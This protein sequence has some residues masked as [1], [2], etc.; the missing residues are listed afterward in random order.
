MKYL[1]ID[2][3]NSNTIIEVSDTEIQD[4]LVSEFQVETDFDFPTSQPVFYYRWNG[5]D[6]SGVV[7]PND[8]A[9]IKLIVEGPPYKIY[10]YMNRLDL[11][12]YYYPPL[13]YDYNILGLSKKRTFDKG[14]LNRID[15]YGYMDSGGTYQDLVL[16]E[17]RDFYRKD[18]MVYKRIMHID[19]YLEDGTVGA[20][21]T[22]DKY[23]SAEESLKL[24]ERRRRNVISDLK[25]GSIGLL[26]MISG[27][28][29]IEATMQGMGFLAL[30]T[31]EITQYIEGI[32][33]PLKAKVMTCNDAGCE[34]LD[35]E[36][37]NMG[38]VT[39]RQYL[40]SAI[41]LDYTDKLG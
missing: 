14:E 20:H 21:K 6:V 31:N 32:E 28:T 10:N 4:L 15:Y 17:Y 40:Y 1:R 12:D 23:Y 36:I 33:D 5:D 13:D 41:D 30:V 38:G 8:E 3:G 9:T 34:W 24:G 35:D 19:W 26:Q 18:R 27:L 16:T 2:S 7:E 37:P 11:K 22:A 39:V 25:I 29:Q